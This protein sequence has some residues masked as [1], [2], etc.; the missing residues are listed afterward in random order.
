VIKKYT[1]EELPPIPE[2]RKK[3]AYGEI[4][5]SQSTGI[6]ENLSNLSS[7]IYSDVPK[8]M[9]SYGNGYGYIAYQTTLNRDYV[10]AT[11]SFESLGDRAQIYINKTLV[12]ICYI[13]DNL[14][15]S[16]DAK[17]GD[18]LTILCENMG[19]ANF[20]AKMMRKKGIAGRC[21]LN[22]KIHFRWTVY[23]LPMDNLENL[24]FADTPVEEKSAF[25]R[26]YFDIDDPC[27]TFILPTNFTKGFITVNGF[28]LGRYWEIGPQQTLYL[29]KSVLKKG[30][31]EILLFESDGIKGAP[32]VQL[33]DKPILG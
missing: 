33:V 16:F 3:K 2:N 1:N 25:Y 18:T 12:G 26:G 11:L 9:E 13:N 32:V 10:G 4:K 21:L 17:A 15:V 27:D 6:F 19:R 24:V 8:P 7:P 31:N 20:G 29:P 28:N 5:L 14:S 30:T 23:S 22:N